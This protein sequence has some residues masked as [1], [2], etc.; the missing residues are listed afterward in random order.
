MV[1]PASTAADGD[2]R[3][4]DSAQVA[5]G[6]VDKILGDTA[7]V[8]GDTAIRDTVAA[9]KAIARAVAGPRCTAALRWEGTGLSSNL[10]H[11]R[12]LP[13]RSLLGSEDVSNS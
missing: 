3:S 10:S 1:P 5:L 2:N 4:K 12:V 13:S 9:G 6:P 7:A 11:S 8:A